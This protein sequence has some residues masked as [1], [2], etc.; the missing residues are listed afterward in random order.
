MQPTN[1]QV[2]EY[3][4][5]QLLK[6]PKEHGVNALINYDQMI[7]QSGT[8]K[9]HLTSGLDNLQRTI[10]RLDVL[11]FNH[12]EFSV[13]DIQED[14]AQVKYAYLLLLSYYQNTRK[15]TAKI[16]GSAQRKENPMKQST[17]NEAEKLWK[18]NPALSL[19][20]IANIII[21]K[22]IASRSQSTI[23]QWIAPYNPKKK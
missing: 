4:C 13:D 15:I 23:K 17:I 9:S 22:N 8:G 6:L 11:E 12:S 19:D 1:R 7:N 5:Q 2:Y 20:N 14:L 3:C 10:D 21:S 16:N 18:E